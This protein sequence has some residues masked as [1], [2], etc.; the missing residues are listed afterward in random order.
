MQYNSPFIMILT[1]LW[2]FVLLPSSTLFVAISKHN[3]SRRNHHLTCFKVTYFARI[4]LVFIF[5]WLP[6][7]T[8]YGFVYLTAPLSNQNQDYVMIKGRCYMSA[9]LLFAIQCIITFVVSMLKP[10]VKKAVID[11]VTFSVCCNTE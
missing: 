2:M 7:M 1:F 6:G 10:D 3:S 5:L 4:I 11:L 8:L 9:F